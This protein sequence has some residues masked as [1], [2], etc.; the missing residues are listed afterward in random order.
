M[1]SRISQL[2]SQL[3]GTGI[4]RHTSKNADDVVITLAFRTPLC[5]AKKG[6]FANTLSDELLLELFKAAKANIGFD[7]ALVEDVCVGTV[8]TPGSAY[9]A[10][11][12]SLAAGFP[13][14][15]PVQTINRFCSS[16]LMAIQSIANEIRNGEIE[17]GLA[18]GFEHM[19]ANP[20]RGVTS[21]C[22]E[23]MAHPE[24]KD[25]IMPMG[26]T[27]ENV[28]SDFSNVTRDRMDEFAARSYQ[29]AEAAQKSGKFKQEIVPILA[30][31][32][33]PSKGDNGAAAPRQRKTVSD[34]DGI[35]PGT[36]AEGLSK[37]K[38]AFP[39]WGKGATTGGN[40]SQITDG[41]ACVCLMTRRKAQ[42]L[43]L[44]IIAKHVATTTVGLAPRIMGIGPSYAIPKLFS[45][46]NLTVS[47]IDLFE[48]NEAFA[49]M[50]VYCVDKLGLPVDR[51]N[52]NGGAIALGHPLGATG[53]RQVA[54]GLHELRRRK[55]TSLVTSMCIGTGQGAAALFIAEY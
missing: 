48:V 9:Q 36:T 51:T 2:A 50:Y 18:L 17:I 33:L 27:S 52:V 22:E 55:G 28:A 14:T 38:S 12:A 41:G 20:D 8:I 45:Q 11:A 35:R 40:A 6:G 44:Q 54:T 53:A 29:R 32:S 3:R 1:T 46:L 24:G 30:Y 25:C 7:P 31:T 10:R 13:N 21:F 19:T 34:D 43:G 4:S 23:I 15:T 26:W 5:K 49:S 42:E 47:D 39:Q 37:V 16:G